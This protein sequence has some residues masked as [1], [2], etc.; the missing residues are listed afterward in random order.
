M[1]ITPPF[2]LDENQTFQWASAEKVVVGLL[3]TK[4]GGQRNRS[5]EWQ[6]RPLL[7]LLLGSRPIDRTAWG[8]NSLTSN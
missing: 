7:L 2:G 3:K 1:K 8:K 4:S 6:K 5:R